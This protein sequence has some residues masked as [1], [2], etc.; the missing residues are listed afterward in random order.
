MLETLTDN[1]ESS[2]PI[3]E[4]VGSIVR[5]VALKRLDESRA[6][7]ELL[8]EEFEGEFT[9]DMRDALLEALAKRPNVGSEVALDLNQIM[10]AD[11]ANRHAIDL[12]KAGNLIKTH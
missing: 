6:R 2:E 3:F 10:A 8:V 12:L 1:P 4:P 7:L 5:R 9:D 11:K